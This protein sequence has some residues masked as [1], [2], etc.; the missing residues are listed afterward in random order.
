MTLTMRGSIMKC[1]ERPSAFME[2]GASK[3]RGQEGEAAKKEK[4][5]AVQSGGTTVNRL[6]KGGPE[7]RENKQSREE[8]KQG[9]MGH[10]LSN[11]TARMRGEK[12]S[13]SEELQER[14]MSQD[15]ANR[16]A[17]LPRMRQRG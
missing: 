16:R 6:A 10:K 2:K 12:K 8:K 9:M 1:Q 3:Q 4:A 17:E 5:S 14:E 15:I 7:V 11:D 13:K